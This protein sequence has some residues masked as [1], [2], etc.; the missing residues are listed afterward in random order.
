VGTGEKIIQAIPF[1]RRRRASLNRG[2]IGARSGSPASIPDDFDIR[3]V[4]KRS[5]QQLEREIP[6]APNDDPFHYPSDPTLKNVAQPW[7]VGTLPPLNSGA[8]QPAARVFRRSKKMARVWRF[9]GE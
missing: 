6:A 7:N 4:S 5:P 9:C 1:C 3:I 8:L 2:P